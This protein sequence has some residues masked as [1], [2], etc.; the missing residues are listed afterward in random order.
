MKTI[1]KYKNRKLYDSEKFRYISLFEIRDMIK[2][3]IEFC[4]LTHNTKQ[5]VTVEV[6]K[7]VVHSISW[8]NYPMTTEQLQ[9]I[10]RAF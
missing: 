8:K 7:E 9:S 3:N 5:D 1:K 6:L 2:N 10:I 4:V